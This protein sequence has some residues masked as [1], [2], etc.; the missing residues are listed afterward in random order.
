MTTQ[1]E[2]PE[3][4]IARRHLAVGF[5]ALALFALLG[6]LL[7]GLH[8]FKVDAYLNVAQETRRMMLRL[9]HA[10]GTLIALVNVAFGLT[11]RAFPRAGSKLASSALFAA[12]ALV[13]LGFGL[14]A[15]G[16]RAG[17]PGALV[18]L[19]P[20]GALALV[21]GLLSTARCLMKP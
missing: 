18:L 4:D 13:P 10:H 19:V 8:A 2:E 11:V 5:V 9:A 15:V 14:G 21:V 12:L 1:P 7:E 17:D 3:T 20:G 16:A 6:A